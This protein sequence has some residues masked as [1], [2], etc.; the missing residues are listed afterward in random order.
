MSLLDQ[1]QAIA[2][3]DAMNAMSPRDLIAQGLKEQGPPPA[4][5]PP[6]AA[7]LAAPPAPPRAAERP[8]PPSPQR[9]AA[10]ARATDQWGH[11]SRGP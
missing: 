9:R 6:P 2:R 4:I 7:M 3:R 1:L 11:W 8:P 5:I 10:G